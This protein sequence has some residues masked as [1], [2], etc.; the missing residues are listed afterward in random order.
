MTDRTVIFDL[1]D[2]LYPRQHF[3][4]SGFA[5]VSRHVERQWGVSSVQA[6]L[7]LCRA[8]LAGR[9]GQELQTLCDMMPVPSACIPDLVEVMRE[10]VPS[11]TLSDESRRVLQHL[12]QSGWRIGILTNGLP[13]IQARKIA[14]LGLTEL[15]DAVVYAEDHA[16]GGKPAREAFSAALAATGGTAGRA[17]FIGD[18]LR[19]DVYGAR[20]HGLQTIRVMQP[21]GVPRLADDADVVVSRMGDVPAALDELIPEGRRHAA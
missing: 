2:T 18:D 12:R 3:T 9:R 11:L 21:G 6:F 15:V 14:A 19:C 20:Q 10:H 7:A 4:F 1:D 5:A 17:V 16:R 8:S 13:A